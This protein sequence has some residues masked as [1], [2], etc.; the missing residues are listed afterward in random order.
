[1][2]NRTGTSVWWDGQC[3]TVTLPTTTFYLTIQETRLFGEEV[4]NKLLNA[5]HRRHVPV[6]G[7]ALSL[8]EA[9]FLADRLQTLAGSRSPRPVPARWRRRNARSKAADKVDWAKEGF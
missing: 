1:M 2:V 3:V 8:E 9:S 6:A 4:A 7:G 5:G